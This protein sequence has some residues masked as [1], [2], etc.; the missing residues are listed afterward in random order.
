MADYWPREYQ[1]ERRE[2]R[3]K[4]RVF[5][6]KD[7]GRIVCY[8]LADGASEAEIRREVSRCAGGECS[9]A[10]D[11]LRRVLEVAA[12]VALAIA[13][14]RG[15]LITLRVLAYVV[16]RLP[17]SRLALEKLGKGRIIEGEWEVVTE[18]IRAYLTYGKTKS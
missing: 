17:G 5:T 14:A 4:P 9:E 10:E 15:I 13:V 2:K 18:D 11:L 16:R 6:A 1:S 8:A 3:S 12:E 7:C